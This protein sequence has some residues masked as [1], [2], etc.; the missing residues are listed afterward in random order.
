[1]KPSDLKRLYSNVK[2]ST[3]LDQQVLSDIDGLRASMPS[4][5]TPHRALVPAIACAVCLLVAALYL[6]TGA[7]P[8]GNDAAIHSAVSNAFNL[9]VAEANDSTG[10]T[11][12]AASPSGLMPVNEGVDAAHLELMLNLDVRGA[13][14]SSVTSAWRH[15][16]PAPSGPQESA[17][18]TRSQSRATTL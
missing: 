8:D 2:P 3:D 6:S 17:E 15:R 10:S 7:A 4:H 16:Q 11:E 18:A 5:V 12:I 1:M 13:N 14:V 9:E